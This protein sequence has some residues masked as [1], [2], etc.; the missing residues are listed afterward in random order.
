ME[1]PPRTSM[2]RLLKDL[3]QSNGKAK[4]VTKRSLKGQDRKL[5]NYHLNH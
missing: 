5:I 4:K 1:V 3:V 2:N